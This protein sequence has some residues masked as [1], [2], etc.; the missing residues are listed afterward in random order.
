VKSLRVTSF[1][2]AWAASILVLGWMVNLVWTA[3]TVAT[4]D[5]KVMQSYDRCGRAPY[6]TTPSSYQ[7]PA[8]QLSIQRTDHYIY[9][10]II[11]F[12]LSMVAI[13]LLATK[14][15]LLEKWMGTS[16]PDSAPDNK[17]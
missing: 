2:I 15:P 9:V 17:S 13:Y 8:H 11:A 10:G 6:G 16:E 5:G 7:D 4:C 1:L 14:T 3:P 12:V